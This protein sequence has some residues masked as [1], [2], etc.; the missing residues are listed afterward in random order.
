MID[1]NRLDPTK[2]ID[3]TAVMNTGLYRLEPD[4][5]QAGIQL[6]DEVSTT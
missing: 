2:P 3:L 4:M 6:T 5:R 1:T